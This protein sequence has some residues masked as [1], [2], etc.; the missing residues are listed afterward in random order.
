M[1][2]TVEILTRYRL[3]YDT[4]CA[5]QFWRNMMMCLHLIL[6]IHAEMTQVFKIH[7][8]DRQGLVM[9]FTTTGTLRPGPPF[10]NMD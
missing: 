8:R 4:W 3:S 6:L 9:P 2:G 5:E 10:T 1:S 7:R